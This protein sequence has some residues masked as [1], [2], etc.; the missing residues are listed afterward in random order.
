MLYL[1]ISYTLLLKTV[2][3]VA[4][5][6]KSDGGGGWGV[7]YRFTCGSVSQCVFMAISLLMFPMLVVISY[8]L[9]NGSI[10]DPLLFQNQ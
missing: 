5:H 3:S 9:P 6:A 4:W 2:S 10:R 7:C 1:H 8:L